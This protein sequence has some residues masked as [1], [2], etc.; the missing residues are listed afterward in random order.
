M[1]EDFPYIVWIGN[2]SQSIPSGV[3]CFFLRIMPDRVIIGISIAI[4]VMLPIEILNRMEIG[5]TCFFGSMNISSD[6][7]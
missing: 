3:N 2:F 6:K 4:N 7:D 5:K 1:N